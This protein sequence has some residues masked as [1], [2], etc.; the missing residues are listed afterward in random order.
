MTEEE[1]AIF[2]RNYAYMWTKLDT[3]PYYLKSGAASAQAENSQDRIIGSELLPSY[4]VCSK[5]KSLDYEPSEKAV[6]KIVMFFNQNI[7]PE[8]D[9]W[10][11][12]HED[13]SKTDELRFL[14]RAKFDERFIGTFVGY[15]FSSD[16]VKEPVGA[17]L[18]IYQIGKKENSVLRASLVTGIRTD[19]DLQ[20][21]ALNKLFENT[22]VTKKQYD[23]YYNS[24]PPDKMRCY[25]YE[26]T[27]EITEESV[28]ILF[29]GCDSEVRKLVFTLNI[30]KFPHQKKQIKNERPYVGGLAF[31]LLIGDSPF[32]T[33][34][35]QMG[36]INTAFK[37][38]SL[39]DP[40]LETLLL[41]DTTGKDVRLTPDADRLWFE[42]AIQSS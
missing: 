36:I 10:K 24:L 9:T 39:A 11:F 28:L 37:I 22:P 33:R 14:N 15:Y 7:T 38:I 5:C 21:D 8:V 41:L 32:D 25:Y 19:D 26:G 4:T 1:K 42:L 2:H 3:T 30:S 12:L 6:K 13:L 23:E 29:H 27:V 18:K 31:M 20:N 34:F 35:Y 16:T 17:I 40:R